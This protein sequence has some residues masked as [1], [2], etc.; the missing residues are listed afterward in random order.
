VRLA[1]DANVLLAAVIGGRARLILTHPRVEQVLTTE[2]TLAE[3]EE[4]ALVL[5][6]K[7][8]LQTDI[9]LLAVASLPV[10]VISPSDYSG[11]LVEARRRISRR[12][13]DDVDLLAL[14]LQFQVPVWSNDRDFEGLQVELFTTE[15]LLRHLE[16]IR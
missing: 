5:G 8:R 2:Q 16:I 10:T 1:A 9:L 7:K 6:E 11:K 14:A 13:P 3:V 4:Y 15:D 12:D